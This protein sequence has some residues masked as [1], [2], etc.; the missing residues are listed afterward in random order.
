MATASNNYGGNNRGHYNNPRV[1]DLI[2]RY[3]SSLREA[4]RGPLMREI[5]DLV[6]ED[7]PLIQTNFNPVFG[8]VRK[9][10]QALSD[11]SG[12]Y[13]SGGQFGAFSRTAY[14]WDK[15]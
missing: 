12:G 2:G 10:V 9:G 1:N 6:G 8:T 14:L 4:D 11:L 7:Q 13:Q 15:S 5:A 3:R